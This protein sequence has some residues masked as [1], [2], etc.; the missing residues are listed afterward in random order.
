MRRRGIAHTM[1]ATLITS[2]TS[3]RKGA[4]IISSNTNARPHK[5]A[6]K[7][8]FLIGGHMRAND[9]MVQGYL[10]G[11]DLNAPMPSANRSDSYKHGFANGR[12]DKTGLSRGLT[13]DALNQLADDA[14]M[15]DATR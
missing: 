15:R 5:S 9:E 13:F 12:A 14:M 7:S 4:G 3:A 8:D 1:V 2:A 6:S 10:D 11:F